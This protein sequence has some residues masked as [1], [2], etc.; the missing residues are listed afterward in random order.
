MPAYSHGALAIVTEPYF[1][2]VKETLSEIM[3]VLDPPE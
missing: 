2:K 1:I 3:Q